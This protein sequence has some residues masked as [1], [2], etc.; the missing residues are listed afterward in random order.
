MY[1]SFLGRLFCFGIAYLLAAKKHKKKKATVPYIFVE[2]AAK[3]P[4]KTAIHFEDQ[5]W[6][7]KE[8]DEYANKVANFFR[9]RGLQRG[10]TVALFVENCPEFIGIWLGL[11]KI[12]VVSAFINF[13][14]RQEA[15]AHCIRIVK[16]RAVVFSASMGDALSAV[17]PGLEPALS[18]ACYSV[19]GESTLAQAT[20]LDA[21]LQSSSHTAPPLPPDISFSGRIIMSS[22]Y[23]LEFGHSFSPTL[24]MMA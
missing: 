23:C 6:T 13:N 19:C 4:Y 7:F 17:L 10:D 18:G 24:C 12:G 14:L 9:S 16:T 21:E 22:I 1:C 3:H 15:L 8:L 11:G 20:S 2:T 5:K